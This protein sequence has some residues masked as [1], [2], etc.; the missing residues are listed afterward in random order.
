[1]LSPALNGTSVAAIRPVPGSA[2][3]GP[4]RKLGKLEKVVITSASLAGSGSAARAGY[5]VNQVNRPGSEKDHADTT[6]LSIPPP[7]PPPT[8]VI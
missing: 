5:A 6:V 1:M 7:P 2:L 3:A 8:T 4:R